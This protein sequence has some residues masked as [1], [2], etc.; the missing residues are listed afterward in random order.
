MPTL[1]AGVRIEVVPPLLDR[2]QVVPPAV[3]QLRVLP[4]SGPTGPAGPSG[5]GFIHHQI[6]PGAT[7]TITHNLGRKP[8]PTL[9]P[10]DSPT[11][12]VNTDLVYP[13]LNTL[14]VEW[15]AP[16]SGYAYL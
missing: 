15:P 10:D 8:V 1:S 2:V 12:P 3:I 9:L 16:T 6:S 13:D 11:R 14:I 4:V 5:T 7:W